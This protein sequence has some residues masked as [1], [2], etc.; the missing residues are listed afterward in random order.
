M[1][2][3]F[4]E[5]APATYDQATSYRD[6]APTPATYDVASQQ[7]VTLPRKHVQEAAVYDTAAATYNSGPISNPSVCKRRSPPSASSP[8]LLLLRLLRL[9][10]LL[11]HW[12]SPP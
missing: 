8:F 11:L 1:Y 4:E 3:G 6:V 2:N 12:A 7:K 9:R 10:L 5:P